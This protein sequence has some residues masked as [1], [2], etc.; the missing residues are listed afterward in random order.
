MK[1]DMAAISDRHATVS[2]KIRALAAAGYARAD[3]ARHLGKRYQHVRNVLE[4]DARTKARAPNAASAVRA[5]ANPKDAPAHK[6]EE[7]VTV[8]LEI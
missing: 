7:P 6:S 8:R 3:I 5:P 4:E 1:Q 2:D